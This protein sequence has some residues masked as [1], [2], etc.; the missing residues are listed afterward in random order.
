MN[1]CDY[2]NV[3]DELSGGIKD[4]NEAFSTVAGTKGWYSQ[5]YAGILN[6]SDM[7]N[8]GD[9][10]AMGNVWAAYTDELYTHQAFLTGKYMGWNSENTR[11]SRWPG[12][13]ERIRQ[14]NIFL[15]M[16][17]PLE[18]NL[19]SS[20]VRLT[21]ADIIR[22]KANV[23][24]MRAAYYFWLMEQ[25]GPVPLI[26][27]SENK[28]DDLDLPRNS[29][30]E[31]IEFIDTE[32]VAAMPDMA[33][34]PYHADADAN[35]RAV[36]TKGA[37]LALRAKLW[38]YA[39]SPLYNG[40]GSEALSPANQ[41]YINQTLALVNNDGKRLFPDYDASKLQKA[42][43]CCKDLI[44]YAEDGLR[45]ELYKN[46]GVFDAARTVYEL[47]QSYNREII[48]AHSN[49]SWGSVG[50]QQFEAMVTPIAE[51]NTGQGLILL[52]E[53]VDDFY[54]ADG[55]PIRA[56]SFLPK[57]PTYTENGFGMLSGNEI[58]F[59]NTTPP[60]NFEVFN[61]YVNREP[62]FYNTVTFSGK[63]W[64][65][66]GRE[67]QFYRGGTSNLND[68]GSALT[69]YL[70]YK[71]ASRNV[72]LGGTTSQFKPV[73]IFRLAEFYL[74]YAEAL[75]E[76]DPGNPDVLKYVNLVRERAGLPRLEDLNPAIAGDKAMQREAIRRE[77]RV[78]LAT[79]GQ[80]YFDTR[81]WLIAGNAVG[82]GGQ[83]G[84]FTGMNSSQGKILFHT[85]TKF[86]DRTFMTKN[87]LYPIPKYDMQR[88]M[89]LKQNPGW[90]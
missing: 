67:V 89:V 61:M 45:Y 69:G 49:H 29:L 63:R 40:G 31:I 3:S 18:E 17:Q 52:Q 36:P 60:G 8:T 16:A 2:L 64:H 9:P 21:E 4:I 33:L 76:V 90:D 47:F 22:Y 25:F 23:R 6:S 28:D 77:S 30:D 37:A 41:A 24:F 35:M 44:D 32:I 87:Y 88:T 13:Y 80:R 54:C 84:E 53:L 10:G 11:A 20:I 79:E 86:R 58:Y 1:A 12:L 43:T 38:V 57:S 5:C 7:I 51:A 70:L 78:E 75:N 50:S 39:A 65:I 48:W 19:V 56:T 81:R 14:C 73:I 59:P 71:R 74:L 66:S 26:T 82:Q 83:G 15:E 68:N 34:E 27:V 72:L 85:R 55:L 46:A 42:V 62:R